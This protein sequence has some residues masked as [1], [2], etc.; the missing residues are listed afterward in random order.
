MEY[1]R[2]LCKRF[3]IDIKEILKWLKK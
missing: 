3:K 1:I 2:G